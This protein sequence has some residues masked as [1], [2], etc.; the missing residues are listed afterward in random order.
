MLVPGRYG[1]ANKFEEV[2]TGFDEECLVSP[3]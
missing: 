2:A 1:R 3:L